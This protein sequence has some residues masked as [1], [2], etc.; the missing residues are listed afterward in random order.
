[1][2]LPWDAIDLHIHTRFSD[3]QS[4]LAEA[5]RVARAK[6]LK[7]FAITD[8]YSQFCDLPHRL[9]KGQLKTY[10]DSLS[11]AGVMVK[12]VEAD[13]L[14]DQFSISKANADLCDLVLGGLHVLEGRVFWGDKGP[15]WDPRSFVEHIRVTLI[16]A[17]ESGLL[18]VLVHP[19]WLPEDIRPQT[20]QLLTRDWRE[21]L[22]EAAADHMVAIEISGAWKVPDE[23]F[24]RACL[25]RGVKLS[26]GS[27]AHTPSDIGNIRY[28]VDLLKRLE[29]PP[30]AIFLPGMP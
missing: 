7:I 17:M 29:A 4:S 26:V 25:R 24:V 3:G 27:D 19:T 12:G 20:K 16:R 28:A 6:K 21:S 14:P 18:D 2:S 10:L 15:I 9:S 30:E 1:M 22:L 23:V 13:I 5:V 11:S 8:H